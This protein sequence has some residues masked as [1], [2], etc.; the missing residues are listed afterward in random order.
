MPYLRDTPHLR[1]AADRGRAG[2]VGRPVGGVQ[3]VYA[4]RAV[5]GGERCTAA[6]DQAGH[7]FDTVCSLHSFMGRSPPPQ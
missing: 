2:G 5:P 4:R 7:F 3:D 6:Q 1:G